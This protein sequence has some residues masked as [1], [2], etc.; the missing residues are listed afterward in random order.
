MTAVPKP[1]SIQDF[2]EWEEAQPERYEFVDGIVR[3]MVGGTIGHSLIKANVFRALD[4]QLDG[5]P[6]RALVE[7]PKVLGDEVAAFPDVVVTCTPHRRAETTVKEPVVVVEVLSRST[8][9]YDLTGKWTSGYRHLPSLRHALFIE[10]DKVSVDVYSRD[11]S[12]WHV[13]TLETL[14][15]VIELP[16]IGCRIPL[17]DVYAETEI[18][19]PS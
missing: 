1:W 2:V 12:G 13:E 6:C 4:R 15:G 18:V 7:G 14:D 5:K 16:A 17:S 19:F 8:R 10:Q 11:G 3:M 9:S